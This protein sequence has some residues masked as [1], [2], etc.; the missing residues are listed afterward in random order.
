[1]VTNRL[2]KLI[3]QITLSS[4]SPVKLRR[5]GRGRG[6]GTRHGHWV[7]KGKELHLCHLPITGFVLAAATATAELAHLRGACR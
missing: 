4:P 6:R 5:R 7:G 3:L 2:S 1:M